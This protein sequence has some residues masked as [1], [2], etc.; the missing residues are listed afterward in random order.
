MSDV[1][2]HGT[3][4]LAQTTSA[5]NGTAKGSGG[6]NASAHKYRGSLLQK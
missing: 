1:G 4:T 3:V 2:A 5:V 6:A